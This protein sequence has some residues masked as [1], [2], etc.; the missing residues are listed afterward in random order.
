VLPAKQA[1]VE[2]I[3]QAIGNTLS[4]IFGGFFLGACA[5]D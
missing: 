5:L 2:Q 4:R 3:W 1:A